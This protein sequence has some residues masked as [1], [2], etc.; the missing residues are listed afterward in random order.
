[1]I[2]KI[3]KIS[4]FLNFPNLK[5]FFSSNYTHTHL[6][7][8]CRGASAY[9]DGTPS[10]QPPSAGKSTLRRWV[11]L[12]P[13]LSPATAWLCFLPCSCSP[14]F[15]DLARNTEHETPHDAVINSHNTSQ[16]LCSPDADHQERSIIKR[17]P[18]MPADW[19]YMKKMWYIHTL[20]YHSAI[21]RNESGSS[22]E[23][24]MDLGPVLQSEVSPRK[25]GMWIPA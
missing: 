12:S 14:S 11:G 8:W 23:S 16:A 1:M 13:H 15:P 7:P 25:T 24:W 10:L 22:V 4:L 5:Y 17:S 20:E 6:L 3:S 19:W 21:K 9:L 18:E 2:L